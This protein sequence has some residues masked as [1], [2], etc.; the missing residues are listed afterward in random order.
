MDWDLQL[1]VALIE[2]S[3]WNA[4][5][6]AVAEEIQHI[7][8]E[9][10]S[11]KLP[12][13][14]TLSREDDS[15]Y[16]VH[17][18]VADPDQMIDRIFAQLDFSLAL[19]LRGHNSSGFSE[20][21]VAYA[22]LDHTRKNCRDDPNAVHMHLRLAREVIEG[23]LAAQEYHRE[24]ALIALVS[25]L[26]QHEIQLRADHPMIRQKHDTFVAQRL[27]ELDD[28]KRIQIAAE[29][30][31]LE[32]DTKGRLKTEF[33]LDA[34]TLATDNGIE[35]QRDA[36]KRAGGRSQKMNLI[37]R[38]ANATKSADGSALNKGTGLIMRLQKIA[39]LLSPLL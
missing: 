22:Y 8:T 19:A 9:F 2:D 12:Q 39:E 23:K 18:V 24:D 7:Q 32:S 36:L 11:T 34:T 3:I 29:F 30:R 15:L 28:E 14:E 31:A 13:T 4:G 33:G 38:A 1:Q 16:V 37:E 20:M 5:P 35:T 10:L 6:Q 26:G 27:R 21:C 25:A 17:S